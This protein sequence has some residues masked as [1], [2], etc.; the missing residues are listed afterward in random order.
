MRRS[1]SCPSAGSRRDGPSAQRCERS[2]AL[3]RGAP[4]WFIL[5]GLL[6]LAAGC[7]RGGPAHAWISPREAADRAL[8][9]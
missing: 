8:T 6:L 2:P 9:Q 5:G 7:A 1:F 3:R 4:R